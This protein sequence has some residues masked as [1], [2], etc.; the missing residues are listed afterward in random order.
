MT[1]GC[2]VLEAAP[3]FWL[4]LAALYVFA[5]QLRWLPGGGLTEADQ[6]LT[7]TQLARHLLLP[8]VVLGISQTPWFVLFVRRNL[9]EALTQDYV[10]GARARGLPDRAVVLGH[11]LRTS[12]LSF[13]TLLGTRLPELITGALLVETVFSWPGI[14]KATVDA[15]LDVD[16]PV[17][18]GIDL[19]VEAGQTVGLAG[20]SGSGKSTL[21]RVL[22]LLHKPFDG[23][24]FVDDHAVTGHRHRARRITAPASACCSSNP[25]CPSIRG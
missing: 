20:P 12:L 22:S 3:V 14:A 6:A 21:A 1:S 17:I 16:C 25:D 19:R 18:T 15:A 24:V 23:T 2:Y 7:V 13:L 9:L 5:Q 11:A 8:A 4:G 10:I